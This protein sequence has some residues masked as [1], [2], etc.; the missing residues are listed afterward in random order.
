M[1]TLEHL[2]CDT[3]LV[4]GSNLTILDGLVDFPS[5]N[6]LRS[7]TLMVVFSERCLRVWP[8][9]V[10]D[11]LVSLLTEVLTEAK[12]PCLEEFNI[13]AKLDL[14][15]VY[16]ARKESFIEEAV[17]DLKV[18]LEA[19]TFHFGLSFVIDTYDP[20]PPHYYVE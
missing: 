16:A 17:E 14:R 9:V 15:P 18:E 19:M 2:H 3:T 1:N 5:E 10:H 13:T 20:L 7:I 4:P 8:D 6:A 11:P 12:F